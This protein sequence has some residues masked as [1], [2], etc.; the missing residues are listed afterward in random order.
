VVLFE[1]SIWKGEKMTKIILEK[2]NLWVGIFFVVIAG[3]L[4]G[5]FINSLASPTVPATDT[6]FSGK[7]VEDKRLIWLNLS[8]NIRGEMA[9]KGKFSCCLEH[10][11]F[12]CIYKTPK[13]GEGAAC[14]CAKEVLAGKHPCGECIGEIMEGHGDP[15]L[16]PYFAAA[17]AEEVGSQ[18]KDELKK[19]I[20]EKYNISLEAQK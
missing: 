10:P 20:S 15:V 8:D 12:Y 7:S 17:I 14:E 2:R 6:S 13:H 4:V 5:Y 16:A 9:N 1:K 18:H 19:I 3:I 11:C